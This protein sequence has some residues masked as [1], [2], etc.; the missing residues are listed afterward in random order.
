MRVAIGVVVAVICAAAGAATLG[1]PAA[2][3]EA[4]VDDYF[5][6]KVVD[7]YRWMEAPGSTELKTWMKAQT[8]YTQSV[9][10]A[11]PGREPLLARIREL[12]QAGSSVRV[13]VTAGGRTFYRVQ[14]AG[15]PV[16]KVYMREG[17]TAA[18][19]ILVD[20]ARF[21]REGQHAEL[22]FIEPSRD[23]RYLAYSI[24]YGGGEVGIL[25][26]LDVGS[27]ADLDVDID[28]IWGS[29][30]SV[31]S[32]R[33]DNR[34]FFY[35]RFPRLGP[36]DSPATAQQ[37]SKVYLHQLNRNADGEG[38]TAVFGYGVARGISLPPAAFNSIVTAPGSD[39][40]VAEVSTADVNFSALYVAPLRSISGPRTPWRKLA[41]A[42]D[43]I[44]YADN[45]PG[46]HGNELYLVTGK[47]APHY[48]L[49]RIDLRHPDLRRAVAVLPESGRVIED[50]AV[51]SDALYVQQLDG[52][53]S[54]LLRIPYEHGP[55]TE[56]ALPPSLAIRSVAA[57]PA[58]AGAWLCL[59]SWIKVPGIFRV[60][61]GAE[62][63]VD[64]RWIEPAGADFSGVEALEVNATSYD[65]TSVPLSIILKKGAALDGSHPTIL[66][67]YG[68]YGI[69]GTQK[70]FFESTWLAWI[71]RG[72][73]IAYAHPRGGG[74]YGEPWHQAGMK[75]T[76]L[77]TVFD[78]IACAE[79]L[80]DRGYTS[81]RSL[82]LYGDSAG[83]IA[84][85]A[86]TWRP[87][88]F[89]AAIDHAGVTDTLR[90]ETTVEGPL[91]VPE[92]GSVASREGFEAL[93]AMSPYT[94]VRDG[95]LYPAV[96]LETGANDPRV[97]SWVVDKMAAR[98]QAA[99]GSGKPVLLNVD[100]DNGHGDG[101]A[102][103]I[104][105]EE[106]I[107]WTFLLWQF[108]DPAFQKRR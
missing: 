82:A 52:S 22:G 67:S 1:P 66:N 6:T 34:S 18:P 98:L 88:L 90:F 46:I 59:R 99:T 95:T 55:A 101:T 30:Y 76:K 41:D 57:S 16:A 5:G 21:S 33:S 83:G 94:R 65:G 97:D 79:Y 40:A 106:S 50:V 12:N 7:P 15:E 26:V 53:R 92:F 64:T 71:E 47:D 96:L 9:L 17:M 108:G 48:K 56:I 11:I 72:G 19:R 77:N 43:R 36:G 91:N 73:I 80:I 37:K 3:A 38:D 84:F 93:Y 107:E 39:F 58:V 86:I 102:K 87:E 103:Q 27:G 42:S 49:F 89:A 4:V 44:V 63:A 51:A 14:A 78:T 74:E 68:A 13:P 35:M 75:K 62:L 32:W 2:R 100:F 24:A 25:R 20:P 70:P 104:E 8:D 23:G 105:Q 60:D 28:R 45:G 85:G 29:P 61:P 69:Y 54:R 10:A 31:V 81:S